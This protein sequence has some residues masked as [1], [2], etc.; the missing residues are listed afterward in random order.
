MSLF[1]LLLAD[2]NETVLPSVQRILEP[3]FEIVGIVRDGLSLVA[4]AQ[5]LNPDI[6][7]VDVFMPGMRG[8]EAA[9]QVKKH[10]LKGSI[11]FLTVPQGWTLAEEAR[12]MDAMGYILKSSA[13]RDLVLAVQET[14]QGRFFLSTALKFWDGYL[15]VEAKPN[16]G[17]RIE[18]RI[19][20]TWKEGDHD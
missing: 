3:H 9:R 13:D 8:V 4:A 10:H 6:M 14:L 12:A 7:V 2:G 5:K 17:T 15:S 18:V 16:Q 11:I 19:P 20:V 1:R